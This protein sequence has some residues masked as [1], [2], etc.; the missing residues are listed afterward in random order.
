MSGNPNNLVVSPQTPTNAP[1][2]D[3]QGNLNWAWLKFFIDLAQAVNNALDIL[4]QFNGVIGAQATVAAH[5]GTLQAT[6]QNLT[7][8]GQLAAA[9]LTGVVNAA[10][11]PAALPAAQGAVQLP[12]GAPSNVL[13]SA[14]LQPASAFDPAGAAATAQS[15]AETFASAQAAAAQNN[16]E[17]FARNA[18]NMVTGT[19]DTALL[20]GLSVTITTAK[21]TTLGANGSMQFQNG[22]LIAQTPAT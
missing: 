5:A 16:A 18:S 17:N 20:A 11:L 14:S 15:N 7:A 2:L 1:M 13:G 12:A 6:I 22:L 10:Q 4:G 19:V 3:S 9:H 21:L 8:T